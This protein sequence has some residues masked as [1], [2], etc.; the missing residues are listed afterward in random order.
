VE[1]V[2]EQSRK[3]LKG[4]RKIRK[5]KKTYLATDRKRGEKV[6]LF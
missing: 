1:N 2:V 5:S 6:K 4:F 3:V